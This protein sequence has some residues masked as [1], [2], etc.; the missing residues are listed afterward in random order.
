MFLSRREI[1]AA[2]LAAGAL[3]LYLVLLLTR[4]SEAQVQPNEGCPNPQVVETFTGSQSQ[5][6]P[7]FNITGNTFQLI[8][9]AQ[10]VQ[11]GQHGSIFV[12]SVD[13]TN[14]LTVPFGNVDINPVEGPTTEVANVLEGPG[15]FY[16]EIGSN[17]TQ[18]TVTVADCVGGGGATTDAGDTVIEDNIIEENIIEEITSPTKKRPSNIVNI[19]NKPLP[20]S[21]GPPVYGVIAICVLAGTGLLAL[22]LGIRHAQRHR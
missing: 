18:Y 4:A 15:D 14:N 6:T 19:P 2:L 1:S 16:L 5:R 8:V 13:A 3:L 22:G 7:T 21:G 9:N 12:D 20:P 17:N 10:P 11:T